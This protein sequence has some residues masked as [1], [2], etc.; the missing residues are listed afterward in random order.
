MRWAPTYVCDSPRPFSPAEIT[1]ARTFTSL[2]VA[3]A[4]AGAA[5]ALTTA[6]VAQ[7]S[8]AIISDFGMTASYGV[9][10]ARGA[11]V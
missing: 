9:V 4:S 5:A 11:G 1:M 10:C 2:F 8:A 7:I 6:Q 3:A